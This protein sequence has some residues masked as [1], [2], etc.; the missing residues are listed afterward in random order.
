LLDALRAEVAP[1]IKDFT[2]TSTRRPGRAVKEK[3]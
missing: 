2:M 1:I 3:P